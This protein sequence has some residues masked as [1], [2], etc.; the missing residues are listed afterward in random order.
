MPRNLAFAASLAAITLLP[1]LAQAGMPSITFS[2]VARL[3]LQTISF[4]LMGLLLS[5]GVIMLIWNSL[6]RDFAWLP[7]LSY[8]KACGLVLL[9]GLL[10]VVVLTM[11]SG[12]RELL[13]PG[14]WE[15]QGVTYKLRQENEKA[16]SAEPSFEQRAPRYVRLSHHVGLSLLKYAN[17]HDGHFPSSKD[18]VIVDPS[19]WEL[20]DLPGTSYV[21]VAGRK[22]KGPPI[23]LAY[24]PEVYDD[25]HF[26][27]LTN[28]QVE[29]LPFAEILGRLQQSQ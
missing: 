25:N 14:A 11:I 24:E 6:R 26:V 8:P 1:R 23:P 5:A 29:H 28:G 22:Q 10:F 18:E 3:R 9:W 16:V 12:A 20:P 27:L 19:V 4:F 17:E 15:K 21:L 13:T 2:D 7:R